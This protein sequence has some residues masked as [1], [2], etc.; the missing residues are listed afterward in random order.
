[1]QHNFLA[2][3]PWMNVYVISPNPALTSKTSIKVTNTVTLLLGLPCDKCHLNSSNSSNSPQ[4]YNCSSDQ[5]SHTEAEVE[6]LQWTQKA[7]RWTVSPACRLYACSSWGGVAMQGRLSLGLVLIL[8]SVVARKGMGQLNTVTSDGSLDRDIW[9][10]FGG[11]RVLGHQHS[12]WLPQT[13][14]PAIAWPMA[15]GDSTGH[16]DHHV[17]PR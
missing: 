13:G 16:S 4:R 12:L 8:L 9:I 5:D 2:S 7:S 14:P 3:L 1:M 6:Y 10:A 17:P 11:N 15:S